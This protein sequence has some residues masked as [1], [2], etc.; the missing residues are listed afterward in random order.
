MQTKSRQQKKNTNKRKVYGPPQKTL[1]KKNTWEKKKKKKKPNK[2]KQN[3]NKKQ[4]N[5]KTKKQK[6]KTKQKNP[7]TT[8][9]ILFLIS[10]PWQGNDIKNKMLGVVLELPTDVEAI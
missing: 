3:K 7:T 10:L 1:L 4:K 5:K 9:S 8:T 2:T 6:N